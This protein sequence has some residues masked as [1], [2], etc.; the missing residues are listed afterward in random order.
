MSF[1]SLII[2]PITARLLARA[3]RLAR[4]A[5]KARDPQRYAEAAEAYRVV[6]AL[7]PLRTDIRVQYGN[8]L[9]E[10]GR[11]TE[12][13]SVYR[14][15]LA[16][17]PDDAD[18]HLQLGHCLKLQDGQVTDA[19]HVLKIRDWKLEAANAYLSAL[20][21]DPRM[22]HARQELLALGYQEWQI[23]A[24][25]SAPPV[26]RAGAL[27]IHLGVQGD[28]GRRWQQG[29]GMNPQQAR[30]VAVELFELLL[31]R[32]PDHEAMESYSRALETGALQPLSMARDLLASEEFGQRASLHASVARYLARTVITEMMGRDP[33]HDAINAYSGALEKGYGFAHFLREMLSSP[34][35]RE[36]VG[37]LETVVKTQAMVSFELGQLA[38]ALIAAHMTAE[39]C[40]LT[41]AP[42]AEDGWPAVAEARMRSM[43]HTLAMFAREALP[44]PKPSSSPRPSAPPTSK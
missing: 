43:L 22:Q 33:G 34:E 4:Q 23:E 2:R 11:L 12:A 15:A 38:E 31:K 14:S 25:L 8:T 41:F 28:V 5:D 42:Q 13:E 24:A 6:L 7:A 30:Y 40:S 19:H 17:R 27:A 16:E 9:K 21:L 35:F 37:R 1:I 39:G 3:R 32:A 26:S 18:I 36:H 44:V 10:S 20:A 29:M